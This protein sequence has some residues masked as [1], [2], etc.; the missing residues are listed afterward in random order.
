MNLPGLVGNRWVF[1]KICS[2]ILL[3]LSSVMICIFLQLPVF[4]LPDT[5]ST[6]CHNYVGSFL[7][8]FR[9]NT[10]ALFL[11]VNALSDGIFFVDW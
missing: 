7:T 8:M 2:Q 9:I 5:A 6:A 11:A 1:L 4:C 3:S 10:L